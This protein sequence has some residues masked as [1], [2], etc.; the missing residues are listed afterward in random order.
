VG[1]SKFLPW[2]VTR[3][4]A[5]C[6]VEEEHIKERAPIVSGPI[7]IVTLQLVRV[8]SC[9]NLPG[10]H[11]AEGPQGECTSVNINRKAHVEQEL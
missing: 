11:E 4:I 6:Y 10:D 7:I 2:L 9:S 8:A 3:R 5:L 1:H